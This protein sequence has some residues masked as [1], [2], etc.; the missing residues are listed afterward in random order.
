MGSKNNKIKATKPPFLLFAFLR[1]WDGNDENLRREDAEVFTQWEMEQL[2]KTF[3]A[4]Q[5]EDCLSDFVMYAFVVCIFV[6]DVRSFNFLQSTMLHP[7]FFLHTY[8]ILV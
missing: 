5:G 3:L 7:L 8:I 6:V 4:L 1:V 2:N